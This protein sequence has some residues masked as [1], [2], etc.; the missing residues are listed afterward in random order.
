MGGGQETVRGY[1]RYS[2]QGH[3]AQYWRFGE[4]DF[5]G[6]ELPKKGEKLTRDGD[7]GLHQKWILQIYLNQ[8]GKYTG[9][10]HHED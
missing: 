1:W 3:A 10:R 8:H 4:N 2:G 6:V 9:T 5:Q 7:Q